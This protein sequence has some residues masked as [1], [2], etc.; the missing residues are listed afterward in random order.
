MASEKMRYVNRRIMSSTLVRTDIEMTPLKS[1]IEAVFNPR[2]IDMDCD[3]IDRLLK[4]FASRIKTLLENGEVTEAITIFIEILESLSYHFVQDEHYSYFDDMYSPDFTCNN[5]MRSFIAKQKVGAMT[6]D[7]INLLSSG[8]ERVSSME[9]YA[10]YGSPSCIAL[11][12]RQMES[13]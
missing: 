6:E 3:T 8:I 11:W 1:E 5:I 9:A 13:R 7:D 2:N 4:P 12:E 10:D